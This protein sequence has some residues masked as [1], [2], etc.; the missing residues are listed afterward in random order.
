MYNF[1]VRTKNHE[2]NKVLSVYKM[3]EVITNIDSIFEWLE[4]VIKTDTSYNSD[5][6]KIN[7]NYKIKVHNNYI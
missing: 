7:P 1:Q 2:K 4:P 3:L 5:R 6:K